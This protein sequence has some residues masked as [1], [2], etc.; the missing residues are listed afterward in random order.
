[1]LSKF[2]MPL[3]SPI[4]EFVC[5]YVPFPLAPVETVTKDVLT[6][7]KSLSKR[8]DGRSRSCGVAS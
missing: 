8:F 2:L 4:D 6:K 1:M 7:L 5:K 3:C